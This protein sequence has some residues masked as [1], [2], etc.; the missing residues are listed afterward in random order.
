[1][2]EM[3]KTKKTS[4]AFFRLELNLK[5][6]A[7]EIQPQALSARLPLKRRKKQ[8]REKKKEAHVKTANIIT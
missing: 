2:K 7:G 3:H 4:L 5:I 1:M 6:P 8:Q